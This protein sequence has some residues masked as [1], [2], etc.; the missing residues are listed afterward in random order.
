MLWNRTE[1]GEWW[2]WKNKPK[3]HPV[4]GKDNMHHCCGDYP[5]VFHGYKDSQWFYKLENEFYHNE[6]DLS[7]GEG[8]KWKEYSW[9]NPVQ[10]NRYFDR[11][12]KAMKV[13]H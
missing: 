3:I 9:R 5:I 2:Y 1:Q 7:D 10:T 8:D 11:V 13:I 12:R 6:E 4:T